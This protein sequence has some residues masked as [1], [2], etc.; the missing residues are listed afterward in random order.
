MLSTRRE[1][2]SYEAGELGNGKWNVTGD[3]DD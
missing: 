1:A 3:I 2:Q